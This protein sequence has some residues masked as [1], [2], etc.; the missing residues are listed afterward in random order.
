MIAVYMSSNQFRVE[1][2]RT[3]EFKTG[4]RIKANCDVDGYIYSTILSSSYSFPY[5]IVTIVENVLTSNLIDVLYGIVNIG[6][7]GA[8]PDHLHD[9][10]EGQGGALPYVTTT[11]F[12][13]YSGVIQTQIT[14]YSDTL[15]TQINNKPDTFLELID[16]P[17]SYDSG[18]YARSTSSGIVWATAGSSNV[19]TFLDLM[20]TPI[21]YSNGKFAQST[22][23]G[24]V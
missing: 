9:G 18:N 6:G 21:I 15:Q 13:T 5:T 11:D 22:T 10:T 19:Q 7:T 24:I 3:G 1:E 17:S 4:R 20:D 8:F 14:T 12:N 2:D 16:T 23:S